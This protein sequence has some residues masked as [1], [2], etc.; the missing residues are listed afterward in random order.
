MLNHFL[1]FCYCH[2]E[3]VHLKATDSTINST[4]V[5][6]ELLI[7]AEHGA[8]PGFNG[9]RVAISVISCLMFCRSLFVH[10]L[11]SLW[12][13]YIIVYDVVLRIT[14]SDYHIDIYLQTKKSLMDCLHWCT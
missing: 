13:L 11:F 2:R 6:Q 8:Y 5:G 14:E 4:P 7:L 3:A 12:L 9:V 1:L 10:C